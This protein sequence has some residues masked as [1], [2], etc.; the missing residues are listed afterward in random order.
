MS[1]FTLSKENPL[2]I[3]RLAWERLI[4]TCNQFIKD[5]IGGGRRFE[6]LRIVGVPKNK[7]GPNDRVSVE[8]DYVEGRKDKKYLGVV[9]TIKTDVYFSQIKDDE[10]ARRML[11]RTINDEVHKKT[12]LPFHIKDQR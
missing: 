2:V 4:E 1:D 5:D 6:E 8:I 10:W 3:K 12:R 9:A 11:G 7:H